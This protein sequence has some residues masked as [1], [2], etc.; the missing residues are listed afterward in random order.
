M[1]TSKSLSLSVFVC[2]CVVKWDAFC[3]GHESVLI[4]TAL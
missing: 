2:V 3:T 4:Y 1:S